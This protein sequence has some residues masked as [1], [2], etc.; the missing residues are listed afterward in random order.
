MLKRWR[1]QLTGLVF[2]AVFSKWNFFPPHVA[3]PDFIGITKYSRSF[4]T[5]L[6]IFRLILPKQIRYKENHIENSKIIAC[7]TEKKECRSQ[8]ENIDLSFH[9]WLEVIP[10]ISRSFSNFF[11]T[12]YCAK[13]LLNDLSAPKLAITAIDDYASATHPFFTASFCGEHESS[14]IA[15]GIFCLVWDL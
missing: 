7:E 10:K 5:Y 9:I 3:K 2:V 4:W 8:V 12:I 15:H 13:C 11:K 14:N 6:K 1:K